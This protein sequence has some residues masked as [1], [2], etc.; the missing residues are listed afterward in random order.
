MWTAAAADNHDGH[1]DDTDAGCGD[2]VDVVHF[3]C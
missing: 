2:I 3:Y 1:D